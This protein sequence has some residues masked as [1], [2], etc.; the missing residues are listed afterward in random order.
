[1]Q[2]SYELVCVIRTCWEK[3][4]INNGINSLFPEMVSVRQPFAMDLGAVSSQVVT[5]QCT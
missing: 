2:C 3:L 5:V 4:T 1:M